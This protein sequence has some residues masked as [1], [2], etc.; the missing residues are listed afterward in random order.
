M[1]EVGPLYEANLDAIDDVI[2]N[3]GGTS[4]GKTYSILQVLF[5]KAIQEPNQVITIVG[6]DIPNLKKGALRDAETIIAGSRELQGFITDYNRTD[7]VFKFWNGSVMEFTSYQNAQDAKSGKRDYLFVN[8]ANGIAYSIYQEL[9]MRTRKQVYID[10][11]PNAEFWVHT[12]VLAG[13]SVKLLIS[14]HRHN[15]FCPDK[16]REKIEALRFKDHELFKVYGR[17]LTGKIE[18]LIFRN[19]NLVDEIPKEATLVA[20]GLD[21]GFTNDPTACPS[22]YKFNGEL[23]VT[24]RFYETG[25]TNPVIADRMR[26]VG[27][28]TTDEVVADSAE[29]KSITELTNY[30]FN[31]WAA[32]KGADSVK[33]SID[34]L[35]RWTMNITKDSTNLRRELNMYK[36]RQDKD[37]KTLNEPVDFNNH[38]IDALRYVGLN[39]LGNNNNGRYV[40]S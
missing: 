37:G 19:W 25:M 21:F 10:Y 29:P 36:W 2:V 26:Q 23:W 33:N 15:P 18:G 4:S 14:D 28:R 24:E 38:L 5:T 9:E 22:V 27:I 6:Q 16:I 17:G 40:L 12:E 35:K 32:N 34:I 8:E 39:K 31:V 1:F 20:H 3:Q 13:K 11:N 7:R 30:G